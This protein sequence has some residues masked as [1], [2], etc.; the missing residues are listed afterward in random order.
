M[1]L[2]LIDGCLHVYEDGVLTLTTR[3]NPTKINE[4]FASLQ[5]AEDWYYTTVPWVPPEVEPE[6]VIVE[7][8]SDETVN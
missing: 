6:Q 8:V 2:K 4:P 5:E 1:E 3:G 7:E